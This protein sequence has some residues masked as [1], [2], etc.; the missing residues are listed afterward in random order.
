MEIQLGR[1]N[2]RP[3]HPHTPPDATD[4]VVQVTDILYEY[5]PPD[6]GIESEVAVQRVQEVVHSDAGTAAW[7]A[8]ATHANDASPEDIVARLAEVLDAPAPDPRE[9][10]SR[11]LE[12]VETPLAIEIYDMEM[13]RR[14]PRDVGRWN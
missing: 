5:L 1:A 14:Q 12:G 6:S 3:W 13:E 7:V 11:L 10:I 4:I 9:L 2:A 8:A